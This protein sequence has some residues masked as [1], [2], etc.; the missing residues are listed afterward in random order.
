MTR[1]RTKINPRSAEFVSNAEHMQIEVDRLYSLMETIK[2]GGGQA[3]QEKHKARGK[4]LARE[5]IDALLD[6]GSPFL[7]I[8][9]LAAYKVTCRVF[10]WLIQVVPTYPT[11]M[12]CFL[13]ESTLD[14]SFLI[15]QE[16][17]R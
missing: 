8:S 3:R 11:K 2:L 9:Q 5:R 16:C 1:I 12:M 6:E 13:I 17:R 15:K 10:T 7:E 4:L 14:V